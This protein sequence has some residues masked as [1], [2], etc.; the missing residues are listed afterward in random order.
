MRLFGTNGVRGVSNE[1]M[2][3]ELALNL[4]KAIGTYLEK[5]AKVA[6]ANDPRVS[7][8]M[9]KSA[10]ISG[11]LSTGI[12]A[13]TIGMLPT[14]ALQY[15]V[16]KTDASA[17]IMITASHNPPKFNGIKV[18]AGDGTELPRSEEEE[19]EHIYLEES[20]R[21]VPWNEIGRLREELG[22]GDRYI[23]GILSAVDRELIRKKAFTAVLDCANGASTGTSP[24]VLKKLGCR[25][26]S[27]NCQPDGTFPGHESEPSPD[28]LKDLVYAVK[29]TGADIGIAHD[30]DADR[31]I[32]VDEKGNY[33]HGDV[34]LSIVAK[35]V[36]KEKGGGTVVTPVSSSSSV[37][38][39]VKENG[40]KVVYTRVGAPI[41]ARKMIEISATFGGEENG[42]LI[43]SEHQYCR[44]GAM[45]AAKML[46]IMAKTGK[47]LSRLVSEIPRYALYKTKT[48]C[49]NNIK[50]KVLELL[51]G[52]LSEE[53]KK[54]DKTDGLK[55]YSN[56]G[57]VL[58]RASG[59]EPIFRIFAES[60]DIETA[61]LMAEKEKSG[62]EKIVKEIG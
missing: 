40:G 39:V 43:F 61:R 32:F 42:G 30:G 52:R 46:E 22:A 45:G 17:G 19:I 62:I 51:A 11:L 26:I 59:T 2:N 5:G 28:N 23:E 49:P 44:D 33:I 9:L 25:I 4:G 1:D 16:K 3:S 38:D 7:G 58:I 56:K 8:E 10:V 41:V 15:Y 29:E 34:S 21:N 54:I 13:V 14:P 36:I 24:Q 48:A 20:F 31:V 37:E 50:E 57:W 12:N 18:V 27:L 55:I 53:A 47:T 6:I 35:Q 60:T